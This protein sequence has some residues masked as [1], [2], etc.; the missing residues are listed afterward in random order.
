[1]DG[2]DL[3]INTCSISSVSTMKHLYRFPQFPLISYNLLCTIFTPPLII[4]ISVIA[5]DHWFTSRVLTD[6]VCLERKK[7]R[8][9]RKSCALIFY[10][11]EFD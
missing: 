8:K 10:L 3:F 11:E 1:M 2:N 5:F 4:Y 9:R 7:K 6:S